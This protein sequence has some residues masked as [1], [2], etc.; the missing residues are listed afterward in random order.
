MKL[1]LL[2]VHESMQSVSFRIGAK[3]T[4][5]SVEQWNSG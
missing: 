4:S 5:T 1:I 3:K 2:K